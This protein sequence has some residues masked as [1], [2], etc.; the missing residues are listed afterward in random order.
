MLDK[1]KKI[2]L[3][4]ILIVIVIVSGTL[5][6]AK[7]NGVDA[8]SNLPDGTENLAEGYVPTVFEYDD[9]TE[10]PVIP[11]LHQACLN[12]YEEIA[13]ECEAFKNDDVT[14]CDNFL[15]ENVKIWCQAKVSKD[16]SYCENIDPNYEDAEDCYIDTATTV[17]DCNAIDHLYHKDYE[18]AECL[19]SVKKDSSLCTG[20]EYDRIVCV[21][22]AEN[23]PEANS[24]E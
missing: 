7:N 4:L 2:I 12:N 11:T 21:A 5:Y 18:K 6:F 24:R 13:A 16:S 9:G 8:G 19:A 14:M 3:A 20:P 1:N 23:D 10:A 22:D 17:D 15:D